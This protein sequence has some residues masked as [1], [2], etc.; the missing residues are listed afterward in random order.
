MFIFVGI[1][2]VKSKHIYKEQ[3]C[4]HPKVAKH[5][6]MDGQTNRVICRACAELSYN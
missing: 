1:K 6:N 4:Q 2:N 3:G 5:N